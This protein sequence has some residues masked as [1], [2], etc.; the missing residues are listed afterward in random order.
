MTCNKGQLL[1][2]MDSSG[3]F[4][5]VTLECVLCQVQVVCERRLPSLPC[6]KQ[7]YRQ[8]MLRIRKNGL[9]VFGIVLLRNRNSEFTDFSRLS[10]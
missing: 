3:L 6:P 10:I 8:V 4:Q 7:W 1:I 9:S 5:N 2:R